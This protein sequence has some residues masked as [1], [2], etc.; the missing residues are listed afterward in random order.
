M[1]IQTHLLPIHD[2]KLA[3]P[4]HS[5]ITRAE[6]PIPKR[7][8]VR[9]VILVVAPRHDGAPDQHLARLARLDVAALVVDQAGRVVGDQAGDAARRVLG[10]VGQEGDAAGGL[11]QAPGLEDH[12]LAA[13]ELLAGG[14]LQV[15]AER[16]GAADGV[17]E[18]VELVRHGRVLGDG[19]PDGRHGEE[20]RDGV[21]LVVLQ[22]LREVELWHPVDG[23]AHVAAGRWFRQLR[24][25][26]CTRGSGE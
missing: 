20:G 10:A 24:V 19:Q 18:R 14:Q 8:C 12:G 1:R 7:L 13:A 2:I 5:N 25:F 3:V 9:L 21:F 11:A 22:E 16:R 15:L 17:L 26:V 6:P 4:K 23:A